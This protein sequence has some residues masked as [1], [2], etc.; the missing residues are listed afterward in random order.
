M[1][2]SHVSTQAALSSPSKSQEGGNEPSCRAS[3]AEFDKVRP[4]PPREASGLSHTETD[5]P[6]V[7]G[8]ADAFWAARK[9][10]LSL[11]ERGEAGSA[12]LPC[13][14]SNNS[15]QKPSG[16]K[17]KPLAGSEDTFISSDNENAVWEQVDDDTIK[18]I[19]LPNSAEAKAAFNLRMNVESF[20]AY[21]GRNRCLFFT[22]T[23]KH[24]LHPR[25]FARRWNSLLVKHGYWIESFIRVLEP[26]R[27]GNP[28]YHV[29]VA[30][31]F[32]TQPNEFDWE[33]FD[34]CQKEHAL[35]GKTARFRE[36]RSRYRNSAPMELVELWKKLRR[37]LGRYGLGRF[38]LLPLRKG[39]EAISEY[40][41]KYLEAGLILRKHSWK[42]CRRI[43]FD[44]RAKKAWQSC[45]R[46]FAW[47]SP[48]A[49]SWRKRV[50][51]IAKTSGATSMEGIRKLFGRR[52]AYQFRNNITCSNDEEWEGFLDS[53]I[54]RITS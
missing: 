18:R 53:L 24:N 4:I 8:A 43:E 29:L 49:K 23:D 3:G 12:A 26:Q 42:G 51:D 22:I 14:N 35:N 11:A 10:R 37:V 21:W 50:G 54:H 45:S 31:S 16:Y 39:K 19:G 33:A 7:V 32:D 15:N 1:T 48:G 46:N 44:R 27:K 13:Q 25:E 20:V 9:H 34:A 47:H 30:V 6:N 5:A 41:G 36:L 52:W 2:A 40:I 28:H 38:E 17:L